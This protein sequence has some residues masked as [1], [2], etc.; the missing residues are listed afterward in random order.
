M[1]KRASAEITVFFSLIII[2]IFTLIFTLLESARAEGLRLKASMCANSSIESVFASYDRYLWE[3]YGLLLFCDKR[4]N[5]SELKEI[6]LEYAK[7]NSGPKFI[8]NSFLSFS[9]DDVVVNNYIL[10]T[11][12]KGN[13][14]KNA[15]CDYMKNAGI[16]EGILDVANDTDLSGAFDEDIFNSEGEIDFSKIT[17]NIEEA[18]NEK[19][20]A[21]EK[22]REAEEPLEN[23]AENKQ[24]AEKTYKNL[25]SRLSDFKKRGFL[26]LVSVDAGKV[27][28]E[29]YELSDAP[30]SLSNSEKSRKDGVVPDGTFDKIL[31]SEYL[32]RQFDCYTDDGYENLQIEYLLSGK[33]SDLSNLYSVANKLVAVRTGLNLAF[34]FGSARCKADVMAI[35]TALVG[36]FL[37][38]GL[39]NAVQKIILII[40]S[41]AEAVADVKALFAG[42]KIPI[43]K[44]EGDLQI[45]LSQAAGGN[46]SGGGC[47]KGLN[48]KEYLRGL[49][50]IEDNSEVS[51]RAMDI[52]QMHIRK[53]EPAFTMKN[54]IYGANISLNISASSIFPYLPKKLGYSHRIGAGYSYGTVEKFY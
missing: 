37:I 43:I 32:M 8:G 52:I 4:G 31:F 15:V 22:N 29:T 48:Y 20:D 5:A 2:M 24:A 16:A 51:Y 26:S 50:Y 27:S 45:S 19:D 39:V 9:A 11:D 10:A 33:D 34:M 13:V 1:R 17:R 46:S 40:W 53:A 36:W 6:A 30:S 14:F 42:G 18:E 49:L 44:S 47:S 54:C 21:V 41:I 12:D 38:P 28:E 35:A 3:D 7:K 25:L 23:D